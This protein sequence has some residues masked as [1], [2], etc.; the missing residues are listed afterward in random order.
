MPT[1][2][3]KPNINVSSDGKI[4]PMIKAPSTVCN[5]RLRY[6]GGYCDKPAGWG[7]EHE[8]TGRCKLHGG[9]ANA[10]RPKQTY[11]PSEFISND[12][13]EKFEGVVQSDPLSIS[14]LDNEI[15]VLRS[16]FYQYL[17]QCQTEGKLPHSTYLKQ[18]T[19]AFSKL[20]DLK[21]KVENQSNPRNITT[22]VFITYVNQVTDIIRKNVSDRVTL[23][24]IVHDLEGLAL[25]ELENE[26]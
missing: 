3:N 23:D 15:T 14:N 19:E 13:L 20:I 4:Q 25:P 11:T 7:T 18:Y 6:K 16:I 21:N 1:N 10:G 24:R 12:I 9:A 2:P 26:Q 22:N 17:K 5:A 8:G